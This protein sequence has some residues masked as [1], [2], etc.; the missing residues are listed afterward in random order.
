MLVLCLSFLL[1]PH[2]I[3]FSFSIAR[4][5]E[6]SKDIFK[7][8]SMLITRDNSRAGFNKKFEDLLRGI[9]LR[10]KHL[11]G[12]CIHCLHLHDD[13]DIPKLQSLL[14]QVE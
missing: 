4:S 9:E 1:L 13:K 12:A 6:I 5:P 10:T 3:F 14:S 2:K 8:R 11:M 7:C